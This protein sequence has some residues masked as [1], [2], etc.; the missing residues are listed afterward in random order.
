ME[1]ISVKKDLPE[2]G[3]FVL[4]TVINFKLNRMSHVTIAYHTGGKNRQQPTS[5]DE[6]FN[7]NPS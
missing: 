7:S 4:I 2:T 5:K 3:Y 1:W 6:G